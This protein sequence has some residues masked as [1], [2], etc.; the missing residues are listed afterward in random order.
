MALTLAIGCSQAISCD[1]QAASYAQCEQFRQELR[2][3]E[4]QARTAAEQQLRGAADEAGRAAEAEARRQADGFLA[5]LRR[6]L[7]EAIQ[8]LR[9]PS[10]GSPPPTPVPPQPA[11]NPQTGLLAPVPAGIVLTVAGGPGTPTGASGGYNNP[12]PQRL[13]GIVCH[14]GP[15]P[16]HCANQQYGLDLIPSNPSVRTILAPTDG[17]V[18]LLDTGPG[19]VLLKV[20][21]NLNMN[22]CHFDRFDVKQGDTVIRG[23]TLG[24]RSTAHIHVSLDAR[25]DANGTQKAN[26]AEWSP[27]PFSGGHAIEGQD[28][29]ALE[30]TRPNYHIGRTVV[31]TNQKR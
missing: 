26:R 12:L 25:Y 30:D 18:A 9:K 16:D 1:P 22:I 6:A 5:A 24:N 8:S 29:P 28:F 13:S 14:I 23:K 21:G 15:A 31:S 11:P 17:A 2:R 7:E 3:T 4:D 27:V 19:C 10:S 20:A